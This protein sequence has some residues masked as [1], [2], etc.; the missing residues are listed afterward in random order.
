MVHWCFMLA[1]KGEVGSIHSI[2]WLRST[3]LCVMAGKTWFCPTLIL[4]KFY[5]TICQLWWIL[6]FDMFPSNPALLGTDT[7]CLTMSSWVG[8]FA[9]LCHFFKDFSHQLSKCHYEV[10]VVESPTRQALWGRRIAWQWSGS[11]GLHLASDK[12]FALI[13]HF[14]SS[15]ELFHEGAHFKLFRLE[16]CCLEVCFF[17]LFLRHSVLFRV[18][19]KNK[20]TYWSNTKAASAPFY[21]NWS[22]TVSTN[23]VN[24]PHIF[25]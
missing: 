7:A 3:W 2:V 9:D 19:G 22:M 6:H 23:M 15:F 8:K 5:S 11:L 16:Q 12:D 14:C 18:S 13:S 17:M 25:C 4:H 1:S 10:P 24:C 20:K 21:Q